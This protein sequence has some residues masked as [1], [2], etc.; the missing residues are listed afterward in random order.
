[1]KETEH[2][3][4][5]FLQQPDAAHVQECLSLEAVQHLARNGQLLLQLPRV[6]SL[7]QAKQQSD[8][9]QLQA[10]QKTRMLQE[11]KFLARQAAEQLLSFQMQQSE[12]Q[13]TQSDVRGSEAG[14]IMQEHVQTLRAAQ[15]RMFELSAQVS[16]AELASEMSEAR[17]KL[18]EISSGNDGVAT[19]HDR[20]AF[21]TSSSRDDM[22]PPSSPQSPSLNASSA[23]SSC[24]STD[25]R[26]QPNVDLARLKTAQHM[27]SQ[28]E[29]LQRLSSSLTYDDMPITSSSEPVTPTGDASNTM[30]APD[31]PTCFNAPVMSD[32]SGNGATA[33]HETSPDKVGGSHGPPHA[34]S[35]ID[36]L[37][38]VT[39][40]AIAADAHRG[41]TS[42][43]P[44]PLPDLPKRAAGR[45]DDAQRAM[46]SRRYVHIGCAVAC[47]CV[48]ALW[49]RDAS[50]ASFSTRVFPT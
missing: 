43:V 50:A 34:E 9:L 18:I 19:P 26:C 10:Y 13:L 14:D 21:S 38:A 5:Q 44:P 40:H 24:G 1:M 23:A 41:G 8:A 47:L 3:L 27:L 17:A 15:A 32:S 6:H 42:S 11:A 46:N 31:T 28:T 22:V 4:K 20:A 33:A 45:A 2:V 49:A 39:G 25:G 35:T 7:K 30:L 29:R 48:F 37:Q 16:V 36:R 12:A